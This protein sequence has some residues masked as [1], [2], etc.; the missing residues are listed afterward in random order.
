MRM[1]A[2]M[3]QWKSVG[4]ARCCDLSGERPTRRC[5]PTTSPAPQNLHSGSTG[6]GRECARRPV[7]LDGISSRSRPPG[8]PTCRLADADGS[9][10]RSRLRVSAGF[11]PASPG[12]RAR[13][14]I[15]LF[16]TSHPSARSRLIGMN[17]T[18]AWIWIY[19]Q[20][21]GRPVEPLPAGAVTSGFPSQSEA[22]AW[23]GESWRGLLDSGV[24]AVS[25]YEGDR[26]VYGPMS[27]HPDNS[28]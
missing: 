11:S 7:D 5:E 24:D 27:L 18:G 16:N 20:A 21:D 3:V 14:R 12:R 17:A 22:E 9:V 4:K 6:S 19:Q 28:G 15:Q 25:L 1:R 8:A 2:E 23:F 26:L 13:I 10:G